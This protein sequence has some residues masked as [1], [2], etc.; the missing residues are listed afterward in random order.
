M[1]DTK[2]SFN[3]LLTDKK[4]EDKVIK[5]NDKEVTVKQYLPI[6]DK[7]KIVE[8]ILNLIV[9]NPYSFINPIQLDMYIV[10][11]IVKAYT[12][13]DFED[14]SLNTTELY[15]VLENEDI[16]NI[17]ISCIPKEE[18]NFIA[19]GAQSTISEYYRYKNSLL[20]ILEATS[21]D[22]SNLDLDAEALQKKIAD[23]DNLSFLKDVIE[24][25]G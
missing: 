10:I 6:L 16:N 1:V 23:P 2:I 3:N 25:L 12:N 7:L 9:Q 18:Y 20:G 5:I 22:Y 15:D 24:K 21:K 17:I 19:E 11:E 8:N 13:I 14:I 4:I